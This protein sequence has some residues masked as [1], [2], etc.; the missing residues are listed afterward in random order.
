MDISVL[1]APLLHF[2]CRNLKKERRKLALPTYF[3]IHDTSFFRSL[4][5]S[6]LLRSN[7]VSS[8]SIFSFFF[9]SDLRCRGAGGAAETRRAQQGRP[10]PLSRVPQQSRGSEFGRTDGRTGAPQ[11]SHGRPITIMQKEEEGERERVRILSSTILSL[12]LLPLSEATDTKESSFFSLSPTSRTALR[13]LEGRSE[14][15]KPVRRKPAK[16]EEEEKRDEKEGAATTPIDSLSCSPFCVSRVLDLAP[17][18]R[19]MDH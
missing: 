14:N 10:K 6:S 8:C 18:W 13:S 11:L 15:L 4:L 3:L 9:F 2:C 16:G 5:S 19:R 7:L 17:S 12:F 1:P